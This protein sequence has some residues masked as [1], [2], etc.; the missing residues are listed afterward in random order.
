MDAIKQTKNDKRFF[1][2]SLYSLIL[3][4]YFPFLFD[5]H[6]NHYNNRYTIDIVFL[7]LSIFDFQ[8]SKPTKETKLISS[9][10]K[11]KKTEIKNT[12]LESVCIIEPGKRN[13]KKGYILE[14]GKGG[15]KRHYSIFDSRIYFVFDVFFEFFLTFYRRFW[16]FQTDFLR[17]R[18]K[19]INFEE[20]KK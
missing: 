6:N 5:H 12:H 11:E 10:K 3:F 18:K 20:N 1:I 19:W 16:P 17:R 13:Q 15:G 2:Q 7:L 14:R 9:F 8:F 4:S